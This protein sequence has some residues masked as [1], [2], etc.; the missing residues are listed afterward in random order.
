MEKCHVSLLWCSG[1]REYR[2][3]IYSMKYYSSVWVNSLDNY[4][5]NSVLDHATSEQHKSA[6]GRLRTAQAKAC[7][8]P[9]VQYAPI[10]HSLLM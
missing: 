6:M 8:E 10:A 3:N 4:Q 5:T 2:D 1:C 9:V 7:N